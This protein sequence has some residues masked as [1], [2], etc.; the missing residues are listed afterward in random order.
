[1]SL[2]R[3]ILQI[4][5]L[6]R[7][8][9]AA[10]QQEL[11]DAQKLRRELHQTPRISGDESDTTR[12]V[13][14]AMGID[15][16]PVAQT[17]GW[18]RIGPQNGPAIALRGELDALP[19]QEQTDVLWKSENGHM[20]ACGHDVHLA[21]L[22]AVIRAAKTLD[23]PFGLVPLL[24]PR[25]ESYPSGAL[26]ICD[27]G[28]FDQ[29]SIAHAIGAHVHP[30]IPFGE[31]STGG[32][33]VN[34]DASEI[35]ILVQGD[36]GHG[37]YPQLASDVSAAVAQTVMGI[38]EI[39]RRSTDPMDPVVVSVGTISVGNG[40]ANVLPG[41]GTIRATLRTTSRKT[42]EHLVAALTRF[43][44]FEAQA[45]ACRGTLHHT[46]GEPALV[47]D[48]ALAA[49]IDRELAELS[50]SSAEPMRSL[51]ADDFSFFSDMVP[52]VMCFVGVTSAGR[53]SLHDNTFL[54]DD[55]AIDRVA[56]TLI[57]GYIAAARNLVE[58]TE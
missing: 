33:F 19:I 34:A 7:K 2:E 44:E 32:G 51:G 5:G 40:A 39:V 14:E 15:I 49:R 30:G 37:A 28:V 54:P 50:L 17:G 36:G 24:Q 41:E 12:R 3:K 27:S 23:L 1:V 45:F 43:V 11:H 16:H 35:N 6:S 20:H 42:T 52:S 57:A 38:P 25:E 10:V 47:N 22:V 31:V 9:I 21:A 58:T 29:Q 46:Q 55:G 8:W 13:A 4:E 18:G 56:R 48:P 26:D 53:A